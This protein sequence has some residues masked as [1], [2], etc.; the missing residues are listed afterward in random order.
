MAAIESARMTSPMA[1]W[2]MRTGIPL[3][4]ISETTPNPCPG[5]GAGLGK[6]AKRFVHIPMRNCRNSNPMI[7]FRATRS[8]RSLFA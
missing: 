5:E 7:T 4:I 6:E 3:L 1:A 2:A 8:E